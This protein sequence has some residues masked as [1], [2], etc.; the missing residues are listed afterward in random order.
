MRTFLDR[1]LEYIESPE[2][3]DCV[4]FQYDGIAYQVSSGHLICYTDKGGKDHEYLF[5]KDID[6]LLDAKV[7]HDGKSLREIW[8]KAGEFELSPDFY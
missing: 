2:G 5:P 4:E 3:F 1:F 7:L 8:S 6:T